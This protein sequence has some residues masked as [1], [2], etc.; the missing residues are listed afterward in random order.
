VQ[1]VLGK[2]EFGK[3]SVFGGF[4]KPG[5]DRPDLPLQAEEAFAGVQRGNLALAIKS[6]D[7]HALS[8][9]YNGRLSGTINVE[10]TGDMTDYT[11]LYTDDIRAYGELRWQAMPS[12]GLRAF[13]GKQSTPDLQRRGIDFVRPSWLPEQ[14]IG[15]DTLY[16]R[17]LGL[18]SPQDLVGAG[19]RY[20][21]G[22]QALDIALSS[23]E[24]LD[25]L[26]DSAGFTGLDL[27]FTHDGKEFDGSA[28]VSLRQHDL[29][30]E[31]YE[32]RVKLQ[33]RWHIGRGGAAL[34]VYTHGT[35]PEIFDSVLNSGVRGGAFDMTFPV[36]ERKI[37]AFGLY[38]QDVGMNQSTMRT[39]LTLGTGSGQYTAGVRQDTSPNRRFDEKSMGYFVG[40][41]RDT[42]R[43][44]ID[45]M[46]GSQPGIRGVEDQLYGSITV[47]MRR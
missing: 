14:L 18:R 1:H 12:L 13:G 45:A 44:G 31:E 47:N 30:H 40:V 36:G 46:I 11:P 28:L 19:L 23:G 43:F 24:Q 17:M 20:E 38:D 15:Y 5:V 21:R 16:D 4:T 42:E 7:A 41:K 35:H 39:G 6:G 2:T 37:T 25:F 33:G 22:E 10:Q 9:D 8:L 32:S 29:F 34:G 3:Y 26:G 27:D